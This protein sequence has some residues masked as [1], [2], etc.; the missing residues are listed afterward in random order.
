M[1]TWMAVSFSFSTKEREES[2]STG[3]AR[4][5]WTWTASAGRA[6][7]AWTR[8]KSLKSAYSAASWW[9]RGR[10]A[11]AAA[12]TV[13]RRLS[14]TSRPP[15][16]DVRVDTG[17]GRTTTANGVVDAE[18]VAGGVHADIGVSALALGAD[19]GVYVGVWATAA[20]RLLADGDK[21]TNKQAVV[22]FSGHRLLCSNA[23]YNAKN[24][25]KLKNYLLSP[26]QRDVPGL[27]ERRKLQNR[28]WSAELL[29]AE[30]GQATIPARL[31]TSLWILGD[32]AKGF[33]WEWWGE[34]GLV[35]RGVG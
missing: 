17:G 24:C 5:A 13:C 9:R 21:Q 14:T 15:H 12:S 34:R 1:K 30:D 35:G 22:H 27:N 28:H 33:G 31:V 16:G 3:R 8:T 19:E 26:R 23:V 20:R 11:V 6:R 32:L 29:Y 10:G 18:I 25:V 2:A 4:G 7:G